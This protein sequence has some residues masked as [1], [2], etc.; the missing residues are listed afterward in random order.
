ML[1][2]FVADSRAIQGQPAEARQPGHV[3]QIIILDILAAELVNALKTGRHMGV[4][5]PI[6]PP[7]PWLAYSKM[8]D[9][10]LKAIYAYL[11]TIPPRR[12]QVPDAIVAPPPAAPAAPA[13]TQ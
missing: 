2:T 8:T 5:R 10:D 11:R 13:P 1:E 9:E 3:G 7:M 4:G 6:M 12:N